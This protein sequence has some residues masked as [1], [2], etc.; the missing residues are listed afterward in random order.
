MG[1]SPESSS[2]ND[3][4]DGI[5]FF[6]GKADYGDKY[7]IVNHYTTK[8]TK[9]AKQNS[10]LMSV[11]A[12][13][14]PVNIAN[15]KC[16]IGRGLCSIDALEGITNNEFLY[17]ALSA[18]KD[19]ISSKGTGSTFNSINKNDVYNLMVPNAPIDEQNLFSEYAQLID[20]SKF[21]DYSKYFLCEILT[22]IS[23]TIAYSNVVSIL[24]CPKRCCTCSIGIPLSIA[25]VAKV[26]LN[27]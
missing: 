6:Q 9:I 26:L 18:M 12:P 23:S 13:V 7:T 15:V 25:L 21:D 2:Y 27:L 1:Q 14:G 3:K 19:E 8:P 17:N 22:L 16:C 24:E 4:G 5:P 10:V 11:R 20:K